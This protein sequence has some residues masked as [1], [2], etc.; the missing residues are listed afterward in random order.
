MAADEQDNIRPNN[1]EIVKIPDS[2]AKLIYIATP[3]TLH[4]DKYAEKQKDSNLGSI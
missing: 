3:S 4:K 1:Y 2:P